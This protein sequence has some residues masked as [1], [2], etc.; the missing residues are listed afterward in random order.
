MNGVSSGGGGLGNLFTKPSKSA[1]RNLR[2]RTGK[3]PSASSL[4]SED[5]IAID[6]VED[7]AGEFTPRYRKTR[8]AEEFK[9]ACTDPLR[10]GNDAAKGGDW[11]AALKQ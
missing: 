10:P 5:A 11:A 6:L 2:N 7:V 3:A 8:V 9:L 1:L 4:P